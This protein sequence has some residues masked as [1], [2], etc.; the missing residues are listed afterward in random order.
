VV[1]ALARRVPPPHC[2]FCQ[3]EDVEHILMTRLS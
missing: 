3:Q 2:V 1:C